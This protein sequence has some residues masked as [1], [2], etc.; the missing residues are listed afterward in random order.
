MNIS[1]IVVTQKAT[2]RYKEPEVKICVDKRNRLIFFNLNLTMSIILT[3]LKYI[4]V[5]SELGENPA[6]N[7]FCKQII[8]AD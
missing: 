6:K 1:I 3:L 2:N 5:V 8:I 7:Y 4:C